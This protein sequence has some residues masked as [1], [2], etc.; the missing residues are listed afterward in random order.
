MKTKGL[1]VLTILAALCFLVCGAF[2]CQPANPC[3][4]GNH[5]WSNG[6]LTVAATEEADGKITHTCL[7]C[8][9]TKE[10]TVAAGTKVVTRADLEQAVVDTGW[11]YYMKKEKAQYDSQVLTKISDYYGG[12]TRHTPEAA[13]EYGTSDTNI[14]TV[15]S[16]FTCAAYY[17]GLGRRVFENVYGPRSVFTNN[18]WDYAD[19][20]PE[21][22]YKP[23]TATVANK[24][25]DADL[26]NAVL[27]WM[28]YNNIKVYEK[29]R[30]KYHNN[31][32]VYNS[33][34]FYDWYKDGELELRYD[35]IKDK[36]T[37]F[38]NGVEKHAEE[39]KE[40]VKEF[41]TTKVD[42]EFVNLRPGDILSHEAHAVLYVGNGYVIDSRGDKYY[43]AFGTDR[44]EGE[45]TLY[46]RLDTIERSLKETSAFYVIVR[47]IDSYAQDFDGDLS[48][49]VVKQLDGSNFE[50]PEKTKTRIQNTMMDID[51]TVSVGPY[52]TVTK[53]E[54]L[55]YSVKITNNTN[56]EWY[57]QWLNNAE[58]IEKVYEDLKVTEKIPAGTAFVSA[59][60]EYVFA[61]GQLTWVI[62]VPAGETVELTYTVKAEGEVGSDVV[63]GGGFVGSI[64][65][66]ILTT[67][68]GK[69]KLSQ[70]QSEFLTNLVAAE[71]TEN[72]ATEYGTGLEFAEKIYA[73]MGVTLDLPTADKIVEKLFTPKVIDKFTAISCYSSDREVATAAYLPQK[74]VEQEYLP[75]KNMLINNYYGGYRILPTDLEKLAEVGYKNFDPHK[76]IDTT[77]V[78][79]RCDYLEV[80]DILVYATAKNRTDTGLSSELSNI[81]VLI[82]AGNDTVIGMK[83]YENGTNEASI[84]PAGYMANSAVL[85]AY[86]IDHDIFF[87]L[88]P[89][90][91]VDLSA[92]N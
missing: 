69:T 59:S 44:I 87:A 47:P 25:T 74:N 34:A 52:G 35:S 36:Y 46:G 31:M 15:C 50:V 24:I 19:N 48:N 21:D 70:T 82:Y 4:L 72:W 71:S 85:K 76:E 26:D 84:Y 79:F 78:E 7:I 37:Y 29:D 58:G 23:G 12:V 55:T 1:K 38:L 11:A 57:K 64:P 81:E 54:N 51:R 75:V 9:E 39:V 30:I 16:A 22:G 80:G 73:A 14:Y 56:D 63:N 90:Q 68:I 32:G 5:K 18:L 40:I 89:S 10:E 86:Y 2:A 77:I 66:N 61:D 88:R 28:D 3:Q 92:G 62:D 43:S 83:R 65:S 60:G 49:D 13:P 67:K 42:G 6:D 27:R 53:G 33:T 8:Q 20:Q 41:M 91:V 17:E 45:G